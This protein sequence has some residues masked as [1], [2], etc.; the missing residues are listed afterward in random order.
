MNVPHLSFMQKVRLMCPAWLLALILIL[1]ASAG[2]AYAQVTPPPALGESADVSFNGDLYRIR[3]TTTCAPNDPTCDCDDAINTADYDGNPINYDLTN[4]CI[5]EEDTNGD[6]IFDQPQDMNGNGVA[7]I[8]D[9]DW[10][11][12]D[13]TSAESLVNMLTGILST[14]DAWG[15]LA[16][17]FEE[18]P[19]D[20]SRDIWV[21]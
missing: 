3:F 7:D 14:Y 1:V 10:D 16:P 11:G 8:V 20:Q 21:H 15:M 2:I 6:G 19:V 12:G 17:H 5:A 18:N 13:G 9:P 4:T